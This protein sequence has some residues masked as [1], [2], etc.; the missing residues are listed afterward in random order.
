[1]FASVDGK[2]S[3]DDLHELAVRET[4]LRDF[5]DP[6]YREGLHALYSSYETDVDLTESSW[7]VVCSGILGRLVARLYTQ[8]GW[9]ERPDVL[10]LQIRRPVVIAG[11]Q[12]T[13][14]TAL[15]RLL[16]VDPQFQALE[17]W[18]A[19]V[20]MIRPCRETWKKNAWYQ[21]V[22]DT[23]QALNAGV[24][25]LSAAH[26]FSAD[27][28]E[29]C[30]FVLPQDFVARDC[31]LDSILPT[32]GRWAASHIARA[33]YQRYLNVLRLIGAADSHR[34]WILKSSMHMLE[35]NT[36]LELLPD[37]CIIQTH[38]DPLKAIPSDCSLEH[39]LWR[40]TFGDAAPQPHAVGSLQCTYWTK[41]LESM[42]AARQRAPESFFDVDHRR[43][44]DD[45]IGV[46]RSI[47]EY[48]GLALSTEAERAMK[49]W[50]SDNVPTRHGEHKYSVDQWGITDATICDTFSQ[51]RAQHQF[52]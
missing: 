50:V 51:Y 17:A 9:T 41:A 44:L 12:R 2:H 5:G 22:V 15:H 39:R 13:G 23:F 37:A 11:L 21:S 28:V 42:D 7:K 4:G 34:T 45:P 16:A 27:D 47:Y 48:F 14:T 33:S 46:V 49:L 10:T 29:E 8:K 52:T 40:Q 25:N 30:G 19:L 3:E 1:M 24:Q 38:R 26:I 32:Y 36:L 35:I 43:L 20:P 18:L 6:K 31:R